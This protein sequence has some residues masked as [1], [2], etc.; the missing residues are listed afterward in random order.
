MEKTLHLLIMYTMLVL[1]LILFHK[2]RKQPRSL[3]L[4]FYALVEV[5]TNGIN[6][7]TLTGGWEFFDKYAFLHFIYKPLYLLWVPLFYF[8]VKYCFS[9]AFQFKKNYLLHFTPFA[10]FAVWFLL[11]LVFK[12]NNYIW[13]NLYKQGSYLNF[14]NLYSIDIVVKTQYIA[15]NFLLI[16]QLLLTEKSL[17]PHQ[18]ASTAPTININW[19]RFIVYGYASACLGN[20]IVYIVALL[21]LP[22]FFKLNVISIAYFFLFFFAIFYDTITRKPFENQHKQKATMPVTSKTKELMAKVNQLVENKK[23][24]LDPELS[25][26]HIAMQLNE[27][28]RDISQAINSIQNRNFKDYLNSYR[29]KKACELLNATP[30]KP[31]YEIMYESGFN[32]KGA[33]N[34]AFKKI[35]GKT[36]TEYRDNESKS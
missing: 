34:L 24:Y 35:T 36:P 4:A 19:L 31:V 14:L 29:I 3:M 5:I 12:G 18:S 27:K 30:Q 33:F 9:S 16:R 17:K 7:L 13:A 32:T 15:Y 20:F 25:L 22:I 28:E 8:Y 1:S 11:I 21:R 23:L 6:S 10:A 2:G 26:H